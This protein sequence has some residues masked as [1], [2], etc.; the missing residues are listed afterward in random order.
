MDDEEHVG[1]PV[2]SGDYEDEGDE[3]NMR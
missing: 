1:I 2:A 3:A